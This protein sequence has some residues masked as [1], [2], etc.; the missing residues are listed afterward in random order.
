[1]QGH[2][3][4]ESLIL[5]LSV[6]FQFGDFLLEEEADQAVGVVVARD[7]AVPDGLEQGV[8]SCTAGQTSFVYK[9]E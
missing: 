2:E 5:D 8:A 6:G 1:M 9:L 4:S 7:E 3:N